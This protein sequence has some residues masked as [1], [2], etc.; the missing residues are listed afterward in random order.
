MKREIYLS[1]LMSWMIGNTVIYAQG[2]MDAFRISQ[3]DLNGTARYL[4]M[5]GAFGAL[6]GDISAM[7]TNPGGLAI[8][9]SSEVVATASFLSIKTQSDWNGSVMDADRVRFNFDNVAYVGH[10]RTGKDDGIL[11]WNLGVSYNRIKDFNRSYHV[12]GMQAFSV[13]DYMADLAY[14][15]KAISLDKEN[16]STA[17]L[18]DNPWLAILGYRAGFFEPYNDKKDE[19]HSSFGHAVNGQWEAYSPQNVKLQ[20][21]EKGYIGRYNIS[22]ATNVSNKFFLGATLSIVD[23]HYKISTKYTEDFSLTDYGWL[24]NEFSTSGAGLAVNLGAIYHLNDFLRVGIAYNSPTWFIDIMDEAHASAETIINNESWNGGVHKTPGYQS[25]L[26]YLRTPTRWVFSLAG[27]GTN[28]LLSADYEL[29]NY[30]RMRLYDVDDGGRYDYQATDDIKMDFGVSGNLKVGAELKFTPQFS[31]RAGFLWR[32]SPMKQHMK[33]GI[34]PRKPDGTYYVDAVGVVGTLPNY[35]IDK[36]IN[37]YSLGLGYRFTPKFF[38]DIA[39]VYREHKEDVYA[40]PG[41]FLPDGTP[42]V[43][44]VPASLK[45]KTTQVALTLGYK[46]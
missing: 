35:T 42:F 21:R 33:D 29:S 1:I 10:F 28:F 41:T 11:A 16:V 24:D 43:K 37:S 19:Y 44:S 9:R 4:G 25:D 22:L 36:G 2:E 3:T 13:A 8:Y 30:K 14:G 46:F 5:S 27:I 39:C 31:I 6:G 15:I 7:T 17:Y 38:V 12:N 20:V 40:F 23:A 34:P 45:T 32:T 18:E 26:Y